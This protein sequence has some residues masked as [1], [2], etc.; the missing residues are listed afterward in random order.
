MA[1]DDF[2]RSELT[3]TPGAAQETAFCTWQQ[4]MY[5]PQ[6]NSSETFI[7]ESEL[8]QYTNM[9]WDQNTIAEYA[10][11]GHFQNIISGQNTPENTYNLI[12]AQSTAQSPV[13]AGIFENQPSITGE[14]LQV[15]PPVSQPY[16]TQNYQPVTS[17]EQQ[18]QQGQQGQATAAQSS[19]SQ[20][21]NIQNQDQSGKTGIMGILAA[22]GS[23]IG[24]YAAVSG[25]QHQQEIQ[26]EQV[27]QQ[28]QLIN[29]QTQRGGATTTQQIYS[30][31]GTTAAAL[32]EQQYQQDTAR[33]A[34]INKA[35][36][37][38]STLAGLVPAYASQLQL[39]AIEIAN[40][41]IANPSSAQEL[42]LIVASQTNQIAASDLQNLLAVIEELA[43]QT[44]LAKIPLWG[45]IA[46]GGLLLYL[47]WLSEQDSS[48]APTPISMTR[49]RRPRG[50]A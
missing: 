40:G 43:T 4:P 10:T 27:R 15:T 5:I 42:V 31:P 17:Q 48:T 21:G 41:E 1:Y 20:T 16:I 34:M 23:A 49:T 37:T 32:A 33:A 35:I 45:W 14:A 26:R 36:Q 50:A 11:G 28:G 2:I 9:T 39:V 6:I 13:N 8:V 30:T 3:S 25:Q 22:L 46:G 18:G 47:W 19:G 44:P 24:L 29:A 12:S 7:P 38:L